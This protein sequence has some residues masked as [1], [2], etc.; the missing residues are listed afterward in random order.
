MGYGYEMG[1]PYGY[2]AERTAQLPDT[3]VLFIYTSDINI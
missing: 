3:G 2:E 1:E